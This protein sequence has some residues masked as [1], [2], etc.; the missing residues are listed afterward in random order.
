MEE[1]G[2]DP[3]QLQIEQAGEGDPRSRRSEKQEKNQSAV[4]EREVGRSCKTRRALTSLTHARLL[5]ADR[6]I[7]GENPKKPLL[8][9]LAFSHAHRDCRRLGLKYPSQRPL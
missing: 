3:K 7:G 9:A 4:E 8:K 6:R 1:E 5:P 2:S